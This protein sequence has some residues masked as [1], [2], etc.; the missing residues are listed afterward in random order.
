MKRITL[1]FMLAVII[2]SCNS[3]T[4]S[5]TSDQSAAN[6]EKT[7]QFYDQV[8][9]AH[10]PAAI[11]SFCKADFVDH[12]PDPGH[13][14]KGIE[15]LRSQFTQMFTAFPDAKVKTDFMVAKGD[16]VVAYLTMNGTNTG[17]MGEMPATNKPFTINGIDII[18]I[19]EGKATERWGVFDAMSMMSQ[20]G[21]MP[22]GDASKMNDK[23]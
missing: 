8:I 12:N 18:V 2:F 14:G 5:S 1:F 9:N 7:Q 17:A 11:D 22:P 19:K 21:M 15:D 23:K 13:S 6:K 3:S 16:T 4:D 10:N 20:L